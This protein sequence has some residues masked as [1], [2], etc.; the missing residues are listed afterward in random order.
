M[1]LDT[2]SRKA[3]AYLSKLMREFHGNVAQAL[4]AYNWG[5]GNVEKDIASHGDVWL[6][7]G[8]EINDWYRGHYL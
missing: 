8:G 2:S 3:G 7:T 6:T 4:A 1:N 5:E